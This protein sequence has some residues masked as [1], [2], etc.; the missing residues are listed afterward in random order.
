MGEEQAG[1][2]Q[3]EVQLPDA[4]PQCRMAFGTVETG[5][6]DRIPLRYDDDVY[7]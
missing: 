2:I 6:N 1:F 4:R 7:V 5:I 3:I